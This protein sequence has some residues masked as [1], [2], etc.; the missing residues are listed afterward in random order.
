[1]VKK[2]ERRDKL[3]ASKLRRLKKG[4]IIDDMDADKDVTLKDV[5]VVAKDVQDAEIKE[6]SDD[7]D[8]EP[9]E[10][11]KVVEVVTTA[12]LITKV[13]TAASTTITD[14]A[15]QLTTTAAPTHTTPPSATRRRNEVVIRDPKESSTP[16]TIIHTKA[17]SKD[18]GKGILVEEPKPLKKQA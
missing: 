2:L 10:L 7:V 17:K 11:Q 13:V 5:A 9:A 3:K 6:S 1:M 15:P 8:I 4:R 16:S 12:K 18:K 14:A